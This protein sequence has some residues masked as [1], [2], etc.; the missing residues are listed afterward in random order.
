MFNHWQSVD[1][2]LEDVSVPETIIVFDAKLIYEDYHLLIVPKI[3]V[4]QHMTYSQVKSCTK[5]GRPV[6]LTLT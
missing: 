5:H 3:T 1:G 4:V 2:I 6:A